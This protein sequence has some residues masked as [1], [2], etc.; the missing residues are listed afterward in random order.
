M[1]IW[2]RNQV[3]Y[4]EVENIIDP[5]MVKSVRFTKTYNRGSDAEIEFVP[6]AGIVWLGNPGYG[7]GYGD[8]KGKTITLGSTLTF[9]FDKHRLPMK[10]TRIAFNDDLTD[11]QTIL[12]AAKGA[13]HM[14]KYRSVL[15]VPG[16]PKYGID[17]INHAFEHN[18]LNPSD[19]LRAVKGYRL[20]WDF[21]Y[22]KPTFE[23][24][25]GLADLMHKPLDEV[26][27][28][29]VQAHE[30]GIDTYISG[31]RDGLKHSIMIR[32][33]SPRD[34]SA[35][36]RLSVYNGDIYNLN[37]ERDYDDWYNV[38]YMYQDYS[39]DTGKQLQISARIPGDVSGTFRREK[40]YSSNI[41]EGTDSQKLKEMQQTAIRRVKAT[42]QRW[43]ASTTASLSA[44]AASLLE[45]GDIVTIETEMFDEKR[46]VDEI[47]YTY[48]Q[49]N[50]E[51]E[52]E[53]SDPFDNPE[54]L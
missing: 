8:S 51:V 27:F 12:V 52:A 18:W 1:E 47:T 44:K 19:K 10:V 43:R 30:L 13:E 49:D 23:P 31:A 5:S 9:S 32:L 26:L 38:V 46:M 54:E 41:Q 20:W 42:N 40:F 11:G 39:Q 16:K 21:D 6:Q 4:H 50:H 53:F 7:V 37:I 3:D 15:W 36:Q 2:H 48:E 24:A 34:K 28:G 33:F 22:E 25:L 29:Y 45:C 17:A 14:L 35:A